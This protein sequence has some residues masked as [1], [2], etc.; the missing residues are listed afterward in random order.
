MHIYPFWQTA[1]IGSAIKLLG[2]DYQQVVRKFPGKP[3]VIGE[4]G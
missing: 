2:R 4:T 3:I 1:A